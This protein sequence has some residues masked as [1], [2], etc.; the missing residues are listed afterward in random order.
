MLYTCVVPQSRLYESIV[1]GFAQHCPTNIN[2]AVF[3]QF[4]RGKIY[5]LSID[6]VHKSAFLN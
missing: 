1:D 5:S 6:S 4:S 2:L 3:S